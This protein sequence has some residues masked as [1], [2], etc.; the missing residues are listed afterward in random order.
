MASNGHVLE[1]LISF[2]GDRHTVSRKEILEAC[3]PMKGLGADEH[4]HS[5]IRIYITA[6]SSYGHVQPET[7]RPARPVYFERPRRAHYTLSTKGWA[8]YRQIN[9]LKALQILRAGDTP[10]HCDY[11]LL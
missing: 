4:G 2:I 11:G 7:V 9:Q 10:D 5:T 6:A 8:R 1:W 3:E